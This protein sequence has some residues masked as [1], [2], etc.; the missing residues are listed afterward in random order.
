MAEEKKEKSDS[1]SD[2]RKED[3]DAPGISP[4]LYLCCCRLWRDEKSVSRTRVQ[5]PAQTPVQARVAIST[6]RR[7]AG[8]PSRVRLGSA[9]SRK[10]LSEW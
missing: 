4:F 7:G 2:M 3:G 5:A 8:W 6:A 1:S 10:S 9:G